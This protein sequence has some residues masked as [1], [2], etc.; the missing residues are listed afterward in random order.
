MVEHRSWPARY[1]WDGKL[2]PRIEGKKGSAVS[3][4]R[5]VVGSSVQ[6]REGPA[7]EVGT[8]RRLVCGLSATCLSPTTM[9]TS[10]PKMLNSSPERSDVVLGATEATVPW[11][12][13]G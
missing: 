2:A 7:I 11:K 13:D 5:P 1:W 6:F 4:R 10:D 8:D 12:I 3:A 9:T